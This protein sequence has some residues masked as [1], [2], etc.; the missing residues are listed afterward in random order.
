MFVFFVR[1]IVNRIT[2]PAFLKLSLFC[3]LL[4]TSVDTSA[5]SSTCEKIDKIL[6]LIKKT[7]FQAPPFDDRFTEKVIENYVFY[8]DGQG[9]S[10][11][12]ND[13]TYLKSLPNKG[14][15]SAVVFCTSFDYLLNIYE[16]RLKESDSIANKHIDK[17]TQWNKS[18]TM[19]F[20]DVFNQNIYPKNLADKNVRIENWVKLYMLRQLELVNRLEQDFEFEKNGDLKRKAITKLRKNFVKKTDTPER[21]KGYLEECLLQAIIATCD[22]HSD[23]FT[24]IANKQFKESLS[25]TVEIFGFSFDEN[26]NEQIE[27]NAIAPGS[28]AWKSNNLNVGDR[29]TKVKHGNRPETDV[30]DYDIYEFNELMRNAP[31]K[32]IDITVLKKSGEA[33]EVHLIKEMQRSEENILNSFILSETE[34]VGYISLPSFYTDF[35][36]RTPLGCAND[37]AKEII[38]LREEN[39]KGLIL[40]LRNNGGGSVE[41]ATNLAGIFIDAAPLFIAKV[42]SQKP[43][44]IKDL[45]RGAIYTGPLVILINKASASASELLAQILKTQQRAII[46]GTSSYGKATGQVI[47][48]LDTSVSFTSFKKYDET[49]GYIKI[50][51]EKLYDLSGTTYQKTGVAPSAPIPDLWG[52]VTP[53]E[54]YYSNALSNEP[55]EKK[56]KID[57]LPDEKINKC[58]ELSAKRI[59]ANKHFDRIRLLADTIKI[60]SAG[61][62]LTLYPPK[63]AAMLKTTNMAEKNAAEAVSLNENQL[64][65]RPNKDNEELMKMDEFMNTTIGTQ[66]EDLKK[67]I[68]LREAY[69]IL[70]DYNSNQ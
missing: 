13:I 4:F 42:Q 28:P 19:L 59:N 40:D 57:A 60:L 68:T 65:V 70:I 2:L 43:R 35:S 15:E 10:L 63:Y 54:D 25:N 66:V 16:K 64:R 41:E 56:V 62:S 47:I 21:I 51:V 38:K 53:G 33:V 45:N 32:E 34:P 1:K 12:Q 18:D 44:V 11:Y 55:I 6:Y 52:G 36:Q 22:P 46:A 37:M 23:Y 9:F 17:K 49:N 30:T 29:V 61:N 20:C 27:I 67:D 14:S 8:I 24:P 31:E 58:V 39:I 26:K 48:P 3:F 7:H 69:N 5:E 50:T